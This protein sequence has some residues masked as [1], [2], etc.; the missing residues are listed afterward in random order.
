[1]CTANEQF[2]LKL[3]ETTFY[4]PTDL[5]RL[6]LSIHKKVM[7]D[8]VDKLPVEWDYVAAHNILRNG[9]NPSLS[10]VRGE[11]HTFPVFHTN[12]ST[13][14][15]SKKQEWAEAQK[16]MWT[17][18]GYTRPF[19]DPGT[20]GGTDMVYFVRVENTAMGK[21]LAT[22]LNTALFQYV[23]NSAKWSGFGNE[24]VFRALPDISH[25]KS[26]NDS[27]IMALFGL[28]HEEQEYVLR[29]V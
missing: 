22:N 8:P 6:S 24:R 12:R 21:A 23:F 18:S 29:H 5:C 2:K 19:F 9:D 16:V 26:M 7:F 14:W 15:S 10:E 3:D 28:T 25:L 4:L 13:W 20:L 17:R 27:E 11:A 1:V